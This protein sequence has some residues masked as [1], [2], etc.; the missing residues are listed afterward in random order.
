MKR[1][2]NKILF[3][4]YRKNCIRENEIPKSVDG[5]EWE[6]VDK[7]SQNPFGYVEGLRYT[8]IFKMLV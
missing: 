5:V 3:F 1:P 2:I 4:N 8:L 7:E 6:R